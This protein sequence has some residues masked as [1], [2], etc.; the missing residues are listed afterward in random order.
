[1]KKFIKVLEKG[2]DFSMLPVYVI[3]ALLCAIISIP[4][5]IITSLIHLIVV[6][7]I[8]VT[9]GEG[10]IGV[11]EHISYLWSIPYAV[12]DSILKL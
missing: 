12:F 4:A 2:A 6:I 7:I 5:A 3:T 11:I 10:K 1:M 8:K 9:T